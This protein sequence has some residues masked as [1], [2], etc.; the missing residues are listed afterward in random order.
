MAVFYSMSGLFPNQGSLPR[1]T[2][3]EDS[4]FYNNFTTN[5]PKKIILLLIDGLSEDFVEIS[6][7]SR[8]RPNFRDSTFHSPKMTLFQEL[9]D[10]AP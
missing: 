5:D 7:E 6:D 4:E 3:Y 10:S 2:S 1:I 8:R 9:S